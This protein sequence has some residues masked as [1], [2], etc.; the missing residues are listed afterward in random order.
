MAKVELCGEW[1]AWHD[2]MPGSPPTL[3]VT[4]TVCFSEGGWG[5]ELQPRRPGINPRI[6]R[7]ELVVTSEGDAHTEALTER[8][9]HW[10]EDTDA[11]FDQVEVFGDSVETKILDVLQTS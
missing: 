7:L 3:H 11:E 5:A 9:V 8:E 1:A 2:H 10:S 4:G 6:Q